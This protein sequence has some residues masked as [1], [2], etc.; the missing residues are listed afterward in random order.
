[1]QRALIGAL[2][3]LVFLMTMALTAVNHPMTSASNSGPYRDL[4]V[5][6]VSTTETITPEVVT[7]ETAPAPVEAPAKSPEVVQTAPERVET[8]AT[9]MAPPAG[10]PQA[11]QTPQ[12]DEDGWDCRLVGNRVCGV[13]DEAGMIH[14]V[15]HNSAGMPVRIVA[16]ARN[17]VE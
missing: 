6:S 10:A 11:S 5:L 1:M 17:C 9:T 15:C 12:E 7:T 13:P 4:P 2:A 8:T 14:L 3:M 16:D